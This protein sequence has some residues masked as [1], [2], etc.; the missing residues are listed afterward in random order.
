M[1]ASQDGRKCCVH[2]L[3]GRTLDI[4]LQVGDHVLL[5]FLVKM[6]KSRVVSRIFIQLPL[7]H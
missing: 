4:P 5:A 7:F 3:D 6:L 2:L 1:V